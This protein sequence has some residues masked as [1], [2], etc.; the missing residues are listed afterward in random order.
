MDQEWFTF[1]TAGVMIVGWEGGPG[2]TSQADYLALAGPGIDTARGVRALDTATKAMSQVTGDR[3]R[4]TGIEFAAAA[5]TGELL[6]HSTVKDHLTVAKIS[7]DKNWPK[8]VIDKAN[9]L[10]NPCFLFNQ[11]KI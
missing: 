10:C 9:L 1:E 4:T 2:P 5:A 3:P 7:L 6:I 8:A 11:K